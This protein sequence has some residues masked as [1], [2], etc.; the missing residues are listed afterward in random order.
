[1]KE[2]IEQ[3][4][5]LIRPDSSGII[6]VGTDHGYV[7]VQLARSGFTG[8]I[9]AS[10]IR[11][12]PLRKAISYASECNVLDRIT[13]S[14]AD[15]LDG[16][17]PDC[18]DTIIIAGMGGD[19]ICRILDRAE[20]LESPGY[21]LILQ[22]MTHAEVVR[23]WLVH[24]GYRI[25][26]EL[27]SCEADHF[28]QLM[29]CQFGQNNKMSDAEYL[30]GSSGNRNRDL[31]YQM[32]VNHQIQILEKKYRGLSDSFIEKKEELVFWQ[33]VIMELKELQQN[34]NNK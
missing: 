30:V 7:P 10:D 3:I 2:R 24:N 8:A 22:P 4:I 19:T 6:D 27:L 15:G 11:E 28:F 14:L 31:L 13:F 17:N 9:F 23:Y 5:Q 16:S 1:M 34:D 29:F 32:L 21:S 25:D 12:A 20:W 18:F 33:K 26:R